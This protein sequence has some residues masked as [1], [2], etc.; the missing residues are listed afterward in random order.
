LYGFAES[1]ERE[2]FELLLTV[3]QI[4]PKLAQSILSGLS[5]HELA[6]AIVAGNAARLRAIKGVGAKTAERVVLE[7]RGKVR[8]SGRTPAG[9]EA[10]AAAGGSPPDDTVVRALV[11]LGYR[12]IEAEQAVGAAAARAP[13]ARPD[14][15]LREAL[16]Q[17]QAR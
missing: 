5:A 13:D 9:P 14:Q 17:M 11:G 6:D 4:G 10:A 8:P 15:L 16:K 12:Q 7:L 2:L 3:H 1:G